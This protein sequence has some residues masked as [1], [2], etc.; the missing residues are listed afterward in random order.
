[1]PLLE[2]RRFDVDIRRQIGECRA[3]VDHL[4]GM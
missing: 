3:A 2:T 1:M 4:T